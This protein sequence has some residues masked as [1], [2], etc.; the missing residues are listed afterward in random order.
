[1]QRSSETSRAVEDYLVA[2]YK[3]EEAFGVARTCM[4]ARELGV[5]PAT[6][7]KMVSRFARM[8]LVEWVP[9]RG[10]R[11][12]PKGREIAERIVRKHRIAEYF[13]NRV[14]GFDLVK[15]HIYAHMLEHLPDE[16]FE[17]LY[18]FLGR[19]ST[20]PHGNPIPGSEIPKEIADSRPL[21][22]FE[23]G[24]MVRVVRI[25]CGFDT[26]ILKRV[27][28]LGLRSGTEVCIENVSV[29]SITI[30]IGSSTLKLD[31]SIAFLVY[32]IEIGKC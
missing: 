29:E 26:D 18:E 10:V 23:P 17:R 15:S 12:T 30:R 32:G 25:L 14:L 13:F 9:Y 4:I 22:R 20:C 28:V 7:T 2:I 8:G 5:K 24:R 11:L 16:V 19:P 27:E 21:A 31:S 6:V 1:L 3:L